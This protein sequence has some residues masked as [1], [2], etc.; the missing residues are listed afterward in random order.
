M[1][2][3]CMFT[4]EQLFFEIVV[5]SVSNLIHVLTH[6]AVGSEKT[7]RV[8]FFSLSKVATPL[9]TGGLPR[10]GTDHVL[11]IDTEM[12]IKYIKSGRPI[13][14]AQERSYRYNR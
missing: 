1:K 7:K 9:V 8:P 2:A 11:R 13:E 3:A 14:Q 4:F 6:F 5:F 12:F 10:L